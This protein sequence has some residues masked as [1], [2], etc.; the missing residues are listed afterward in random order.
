MFKRIEKGERK[1]MPVSF[2]VAQPHAQYEK[3]IL[4]MA[5]AHVSP[6]IQVDRDDSG[7]Q[8]AKQNVG[9]TRTDLIHICLQNRNGMSWCR[10]WRGEE[11][12]RGHRG[13]N[14]DWGRG[15]QELMQEAGE[16]TL[17][18]GRRLLLLLPDVGTWPDSQASSCAY[19]CFLLYYT[20]Y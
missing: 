1:D 12:E 15:R 16:E 13:R 10:N 3:C 5:S 4:K 19:V 8:R 20:L 6:G 2:Q 9:R 18:V 14:P 7:P 17:P 11:S